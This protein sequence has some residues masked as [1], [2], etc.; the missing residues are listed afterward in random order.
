MSYDFSV[1][2]AESY[3]GIDGKKLLFLAYLKGVWSECFYFNS[4]DL[5]KKEESVQSFLLPLARGNCLCPSA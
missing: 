1:Y 3:M 4:N 2:C 5:Y